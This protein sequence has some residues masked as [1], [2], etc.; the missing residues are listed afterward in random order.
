MPQK[1][2]IIICGP[3]ASGKTSLA[4]QLAQHFNTSIISADSRQC[5]RELNIGVA[6]PSA[7]ELAAVKHYFIASHSIHDEMNAAVFEQYALNAAEEIFSGND[8]AVM[9]GGT[10]LYINAFC[11][12]MDEI[13][14]VPQQVSDELE[15]NYKEKGIAWLQ[16]EIQKHDPQYFAGGEIHNPHRLLRALGVQLASGRSI[17]EFQKGS[18]TERPFRIIKAGLDVPRSIL[19]ERI[20]HRVDMMMEAG[21]LKEAEQLYPYRHLKALQTVGYAELFDHFDNKHSLETAVVLIKQNTRHYAKRQMTW[22]RKDAGI[23]WEEEWTIDKLIN[24]IK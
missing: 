6:R 18:N 14:A 21:L 9:A 11:N 12:G 13:P 17:R 20:N 24:L 23:H 10:G 16:E 2:C 3:T 4:I 1:T 8:I 22:F 19:Y 15:K 5:F 7:A